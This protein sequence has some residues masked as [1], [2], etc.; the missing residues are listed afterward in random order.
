MSSSLSP[1]SSTPTPSQQSQSSSSPSSLADN[2]SAFVDGPSIGK[3][4]VDKVKDILVKP[5]NGKRSDNGGF[6]YLTISGNP[7]ERGFSHGKLIG[8]RIIVFFRTFAFFVWTETGRDILFFMEM[9]ND[10]FAPIVQE[11]YKECYDEMK[12]IADGVVEFVKENADKLKDASGGSIIQGGKIVLP[13]ESHINVEN[14]NSREGY[15][16]G[17]ILV[18]I[19]VSVIFLLNNIVSIDYLYSKL[20]ILLAK[21]EKLNKKPM[22]AEFVSTPSGGQAVS[23]NEGGGG[24]GEGE[25]GGDTSTEHTGFGGVN[26]MSFKELFFGGDKCSA[27]MAVGSSHTEGGEVVC[28]HITFDNFLTGQFNNIILYIEAPTPTTTPPTLGSGSTPS[29]QPSSNSILMQTFPGGIWSSTDFFVTSAGFIGTETTIGG[30]MAFELN[31]PI[32][33]RARKAMEFS[34]TLDDYVKYLKQDNSGDYANTWYIAKVNNIPIPATST[35][36]TSSS[37]KVEEEIMRI[38]LGLKYV[39]VERTKDGYFI[40]FNACYDARIRNIECFNDGFYDIRRHSGARRVR[41]EQLMQQHKGKINA[42]LAK[43]IISDHMDVYTNTELKCSRTVCAHY[44]LDKREFM[45]Q[46]SRPKPY[47][48]R[49]AVDAKI[50]TSTLCR[51][52]KFI[53]RYGNACGTPFK[54]NEFCNKH[55]Q[56]EYQRQFLEDRDTQPWVICSSVRVSESAEKIVKAIE[57]DPDKTGDIVVANIPTPTTTAIPTTIPTTTPIITEPTTVPTIAPTTDPIAA[58]TTAP[59]TSTALNVIKQAVTKSQQLRNS[60]R[61][62][63]R[64]Y[65]PSSRLLSSGHV[66][67]GNATHDTSK[68]LKDFMK[69][70]KN[71]KGNSY[72]KKNTRRNNHNK[73]DKNI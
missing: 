21:N 54:K 58:P 61:L 13:K 6:I 30:F 48:P 41:L 53:A 40:G 52:M 45:S 57:V 69:M 63:N 55:I 20:P 72:N 73:S 43:I 50:C 70:I 37:P 18:D 22:Y 62:S 32:C 26:S 39:N 11:K 65:S 16:D 60:S 56:W 31:A 51:N 28:A 23:V 64:L 35:S 7:Y 36:D 15:T 71:K 1:L 14:A 12:G 33:V 46:E 59:P 27:F 44:E 49:G 42:K 67:G 19:T 3:I 34:K 38:E 10:F 68:E 66:G 5:P 4:I 29:T 9:I 2:L 24:R 8:D 47:Q 17:K 25:G